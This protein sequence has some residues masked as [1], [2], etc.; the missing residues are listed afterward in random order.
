MTHMTVPDAEL[1]QALPRLAPALAAYLEA[2]KAAASARVIRDGR[3]DRD[4]ADSEQRA[5]HGLAWIGATIEAVRQSARWGEGLAAAGQLGS[6]ESL[7]L[8]V[9]LG[10]YLEQLSTGIA[11]SQN[12]VARPAELGLAR[13]RAAPAPAPRRGAAARPRQHPRDPPRADRARPPRRQ[14]RRE[15]RRRD[16]RHDP[17][18]VPP[19]RAERIVAARARLA[20][21]RRADPDAIIAEMAELGIFG[22]CIA[23]GARRP[24]PRQARDVRRHRGAEPR[25]DRRR[26]ARH[27][28]ARSPA[29]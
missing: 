11:M 28:L 26:L 2:A 18:P 19:L 7:L 10:E 14:H 8:R 5:L 9:G 15:P 27:P 4:L 1:I 29:S 6:G 25:L 13:G 20:P 3:V 23:R 12:E 22:V 17:R 16:A 21:R 24:R